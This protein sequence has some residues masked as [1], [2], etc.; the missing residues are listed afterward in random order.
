[1]GQLEAYGLN[2]IY[3]TGS[4]VGLLSTYI[5][6]ELDSNTFESFKSYFYSSTFALISKKA[7]KLF[8]PAL[9]VSTNEGAFYKS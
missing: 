1:M 4:M 5:A 6:E 7:I 3:L 8:K 9:T 2:E